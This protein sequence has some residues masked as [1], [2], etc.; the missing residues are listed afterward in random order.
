MAGKR[1]KARPDAERDE[2][3]EAE[4]GRR[5]AALRCARGR[6]GGQQ[7]DERCRAV[8]RA[9]QRAPRRRRRSP[10]CTLSVS[11]WRTRC[12]TAARRAPDA[13][14][15]PA[16][17]PPP[18]PAAGCRDS[19][20]RSAARTRTAPISVNSRVRTPSTSSVLHRHARPR[21]AL[22]V[23]RGNAPA[24]A[25]HHG[26]ELRLRLLG[27]DARLQARRGEQ[28]ELIAIAPELLH[29]TSPAPR[30][31][32]SRSGN[33]KSGGITPM[34]VCGSPPSVSVLPID[35]AIVAE[36]PLP[37]SVAED[38]DELGLPGPSSAAVNVRPK[39]GAAAEDV[40]HAAGALH[41]EARARRT[42]R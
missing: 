30:T 21:V 36:Q 19:R 33:A 41:A 3:R 28:E 6:F 4:H 38:D 5:R 12:A 42:P 8:R 13:A 35:R 26:I 20:T 40:E 23:S 32:A 17:A 34:T 11:S 37:Q 7:R 9:K 14:R 24:D 1:P 27:A 39:S 29:R 15:S 22:C 10:G 2:Q 31:A 25:I 16:A 18:A